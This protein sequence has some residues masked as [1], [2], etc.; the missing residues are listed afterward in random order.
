MN[1]K[2]SHIFWFLLIFLLVACNVTPSDESGKLVNNV[3]EFTAAIEQAQPGDRI[4][5][6]NG[7]W[8]DV[9]LKFSAKGTAE[10][11]I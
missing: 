6:A 3:A 8:T 10:N 2:V 1:L 7:T 4:I 11:L 5:L 9:E